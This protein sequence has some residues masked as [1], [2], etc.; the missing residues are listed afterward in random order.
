MMQMIKWAYEH[1]RDN[2]EEAMGYAHKAMTLKEDH[3]AAADWC[4]EM[5]KGHLAFNT[6]GRNVLDK[7]MRDIKDMPEHAN[8]APGLL[9]VYNDLYADVMRRTTEVQTLIGM[10]R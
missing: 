4:I 3:R 10:Y 9:A 7:M 8:I 6:A 1:V 5:A 2:V